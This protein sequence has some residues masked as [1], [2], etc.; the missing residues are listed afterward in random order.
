MEDYRQGKFKVNV[1]DGKRRSRP[2][3]KGR[4]A[5]LEV[6]VVSD[7]SPEDARGTI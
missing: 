4:D 2:R 3:R 1:V 7:M 6:T 5:V